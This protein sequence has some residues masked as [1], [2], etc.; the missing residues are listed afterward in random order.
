MLSLLLLVDGVF[1]AWAM[2]ATGAPA[3]NYLQWQFLNGSHTAPTAG[4]SGAARTCTLPQ[5]P[6]TDELRFFRNDT[7]NPDAYYEP[8]S[9]GGSTQNLA[10]RE[11]PLAISGDAE[12]YNHR[13]GNDDYTQPGN[14]FRLMAPDA[15]ERLMDNIR[16]AMQGVPTDIV[17]R[18]VAHFYRADPAYGVGVATRMGLTEVDLPW[19]QAAE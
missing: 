12:R 17:R 14:L 11:P 7:G 1:L 4:L 10:F 6:G 13:D 5:T 3:A 19:A 16:D 8:N 15:R 9:V 2:Y 18:Q